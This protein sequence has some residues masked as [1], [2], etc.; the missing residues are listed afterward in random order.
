VHHAIAKLDRRQ[1]GL[2]P[3]VPIG[4][5]HSRIDKRQLNVV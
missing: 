4:R 5:T 2:R 1:S 3:L